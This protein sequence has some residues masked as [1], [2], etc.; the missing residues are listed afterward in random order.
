MM[1]EMISVVVVTYNQATTIGRTLD[2]ILMQRCHLPV[3]IVVGEDCSTDGTR[4]ICRAYA[5]K[6]PDTIRLFCNERNKGITDNYFDC[7]LACR[8]KYIAD[9]AGDDFWTDPEKLEKEV[10]VMEAHPEVTMV[11]TN[12]QY[13]NEQTGETS[14]SRQRQHAPVTPGRDLLRDIITQRNMSVFHLCTALYR[15]DIFRMAYEEDRDLFR[16]KDLVSEDMQVA[17]S[18]AWHGDIAYLP[19]VTL[20]Y[21]IEGQGVSN[22]TDE[23]KLFRFGRKNT[24]LIRRLAG[25]G[26]ID[27]RDFLRQRL[28]EL[29]MHA[30]RA[31]DPELREEVVAC[32]QS[33]QVTPSAKSRLL[34]TVMRHEWLWKAGLTLRKAV[35]T[36]KQV[37]H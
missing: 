28:Y 27:I 9:C 4:D 10:R 3:E 19:D 29:G 37:S 26:Q 12:W 13:Y 15:T 21:S 8:G 36:L 23:R 25:K 14:P 20:N 16:N 22:T 2:A 24:E 35:R 32:A 33:W 5:E 6:H 1:E 7:L 34:M 31:H 17:F 11:I 30:F 18:M